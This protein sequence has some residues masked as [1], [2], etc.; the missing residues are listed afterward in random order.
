MLGSDR[1]FFFYLFSYFVQ[2]T[3]SQLVL[4]LYST[5]IIF[6]MLRMIA[7]HLTSTFYRHSFIVI[8]MN[9]TVL[10]AGIIV[11]I[12]GTM[13]TKIET[14]MGMGITGIPRIILGI[15]VGM[16]ASV[17]GFP[18]GWK[19]MLGDSRGDGKI[20]YRIPAGM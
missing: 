6:F 10:T 13:D 5:S 4:A 20:L 11:G 19:E 17:V 8:M 9:T 1:D 14:C 3:I 7:S 2:K 16:E 15:P 12:T 18:R